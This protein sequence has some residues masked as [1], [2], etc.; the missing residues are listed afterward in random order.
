MVLIFN[1]EEDVESDDDFQEVLAPKKPKM[2]YDKT[3]RFQNK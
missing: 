1:G 2:N 3:R